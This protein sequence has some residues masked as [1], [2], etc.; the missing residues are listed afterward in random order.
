ME[1]LTVGRND[2]GQRLDRFLRKYLKGA[3]LGYIYK[4]I[5][6]DV[7]VNGRRVS[8]ESIISE[9]DEISLYLPPGELEKFTGSRGGNGENA[10]KT[11]TSQG[12]DE[13]KS[14]IIRA[15]DVIYEDENILA[16]FKPYGLLTHGD[17]RENRNTLV[18]HVTDYLIAKGDYVPRIEKSFVPAA[19]NRLD[20]NTTG[21]V[22]FGKNAPALRKLNSMIR[23]GDMVSKFYLT[24]T[25]GEMQGPLFLKGS[26]VKDEK[27]NRV[28]ISP[29]GSQAEN[30]KAIET[31]ARP[32]LTGGGYTLAEVE[33]VTGRTHQI[34][35]H[36]A[37]AGYPVAGDE[38]YGDRKV[39]RMLAEKYGL[40]AQLLHA[41]RLHV[42]DAGQPLEYLK[43]RTFMSPLPSMGEKVCRGIF[44]SEG[45][46]R[47]A[48][49]LSDR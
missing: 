15:L 34:R 26:L 39:N 36:L 4:I 41:Y 40:R 32:I 17:S 7:K 37:S 38:K 30:E 48:G 45:F 13:K 8:R 25:A 2:S 24:V 28:S 5:R 33:L 1:K 14:R 21:I 49:I 27:T 46:D 29:E 10:G 43:G 35:A 16:A 19:V 3:S 18:N 22:L 42:N 11:G 23:Q 6:K 47:A 44:G 20:R 9:G 12:P 31:I